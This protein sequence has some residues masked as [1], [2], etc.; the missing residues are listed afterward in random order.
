VRVLEEAFD[1]VRQG[2][3]VKR[4]LKF[5]T[6]LKDGPFSERGICSETICQGAGKGR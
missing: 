1:T 5:D 3:G 4:G 6:C 2:G